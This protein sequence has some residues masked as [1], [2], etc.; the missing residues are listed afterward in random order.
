VA[1]E[2]V[3]L[4]ASHWAGLVAALLVFAASCSSYDPAAEE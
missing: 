4:V 1:G 2:I 3:L